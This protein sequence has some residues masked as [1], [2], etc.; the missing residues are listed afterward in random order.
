MG[1]DAGLGSDSPVNSPP[2]GAVPLHTCSSTQ[3][4]FSVS[5]LVIEPGRWSF[6]LV[7]VQF[8]VPRSRCTRLMCSSD[9]GTLMKKRRF[10]VYWL[11]EC[12]LSELDGAVELS[13][14]ELERWW[15]KATSTETSSVD[16]TNTNKTFLN[17]SEGAT[18]AFLHNPSFLI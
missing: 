17:K 1:P 8:S 7:P 11:L 3:L 5:S 10:H 15:F 6:S 9:C 12:L 14:T 13:R 4:G 18:V 2:H 16:S